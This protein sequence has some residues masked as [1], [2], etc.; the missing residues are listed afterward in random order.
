[1]VWLW[2]R[3]VGGRGAG[4]RL[5]G[6]AG[7]LRAAFAHGGDLPPAWRGVAAAAELASLAGGA[8]AQRQL[9]AAD[10]TQLPWWTVFGVVLASTGLARV[11]PAGPVAGGAWQIREYR[12][13]G[14]S[15][16]AGVWAVLAGGFSSTVAALGLL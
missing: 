5:P 12:R 2:A 3:A 14:A 13:R 16:A 6:V 4:G 1:G 10:G 8:A 9:L 11:M 7:D 15:A